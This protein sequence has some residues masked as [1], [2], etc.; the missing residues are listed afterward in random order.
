M[1]VVL[2]EDVVNLKLIDNEIVDLLKSNKVNS[3]SSVVDKI[4]KIIVCV[5]NLVI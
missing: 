4:G 3:S 5:K 1:K 2:V